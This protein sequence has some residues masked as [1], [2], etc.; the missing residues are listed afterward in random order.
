LKHLSVA[1]LAFAKGIFGLLALGDIDYDNGDPYYFASLVAGG[2]QPRI[3][4]SQ[5]WLDEDNSAVIFIIGSTSFLFWFHPCGS[6]KRIYDFWSHIF[7]RYL[8][9]A[10]VST[11]T[12]YRKQR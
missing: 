6:A 12:R 1:I 7:S 8:P 10:W 4:I 11:L 3:V 9:D 2:L 5:N